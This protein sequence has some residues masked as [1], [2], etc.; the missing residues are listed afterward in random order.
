MVSPRNDNVGIEQAFACG[1]WIGIRDHTRQSR[2]A[3]QDRVHGH[4]RP[5][6]LLR[7]YMPLYL[8]RIRAQPALQLLALAR[9]R[10]D[11]FCS[12]FY[13]RGRVIELAQFLSAGLAEFFNRIFNF[14]IGTAANF[15][16]SHCRA[17][18]GLDN[19]FYRILC[20]LN[21]FLRGD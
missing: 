8:F 15:F 3:R 18:I 5:S 17:A 11:D 20:S 12:V 4:A 16:L 9:S 7:P 19:L 6:K 10:G 13:L 1:L 14:E 2:V 21:D